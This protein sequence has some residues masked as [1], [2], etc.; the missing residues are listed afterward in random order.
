MAKSKYV[1]LRF[2]VLFSV[3]FPMVLPPFSFSCFNY[4]C[5]ILPVGRKETQNANLNLQ[6]WLMQFPTQKPFMAHGYSYTHILTLSLAFGVS[7]DVATLLPLPQDSQIPVSSVTIFPLRDLCS[8]CPLSLAFPSFPYPTAGVDTHV[9]VLKPA[10]LFPT[11]NSLTWWT[12]TASSLHFGHSICL[13]ALCGLHVF[14][15]R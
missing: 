14:V 4:S 13:C 5:L 10:Q 12:L 8:S 2:P 1:S 15:P 11:Q 6:L 3:F 9:K 7:P